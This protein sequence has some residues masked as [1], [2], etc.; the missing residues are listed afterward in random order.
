[1]NVYA[2]TVEWTVVDQL[3]YLRRNY[4]AT[5]GRTRAKT[6]HIEADTQAEAEQAAVLH[7]RMDDP[8]AK[9]PV[10]LS[11]LTVLTVFKGEP[12]S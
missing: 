4:T 2:V 9:L 11:Y 12:L 3:A 1:M 10:A 5:Y 7:V 8:H 6:L